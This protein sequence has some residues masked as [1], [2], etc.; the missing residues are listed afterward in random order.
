MSCSSVP[1]CSSGDWWKDV[2]PRFREPAKALV[3]MDAE[4]RSRVGGAFRRRDDEAPRGSGQ[5]EPASPHQH[6]ITRLAHFSPREG[7]LRQLQAGSAA[8]SGSSAPLSL[9]PPSPLLLSLFRTFRSSLLSCSASS[10]ALSPPHPPHPPPLAAC[11][12]GLLLLLVFFAAARFDWASRGA[13][14]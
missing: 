9:S 10:P 11:A 3:G 6:R 14:F 2:R 4:P 7:L 1:G 8:C 5:D 12:P 13:A